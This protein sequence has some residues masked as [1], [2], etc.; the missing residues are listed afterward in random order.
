MV[1]GKVV[2]HYEQST[3]AS[4]LLKSILNDKINTKQLITSDD[5]NVW[6][7]NYDNLIKYNIQKISFQKTQ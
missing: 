7:F 2:S 4:K 5:A 3:L 1:G 6:Y